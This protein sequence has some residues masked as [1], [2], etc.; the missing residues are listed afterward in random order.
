MG[1]NKLL[2]PLGRSTVIG[3]LLATLTG[4]FAECVLVTDHPDAYRE[5][6]VSLTADFITGPQKNSLTGIHAGLTVSSTPYNFVVAGDMPFVAPGLVRCLAE[7]CAGYDVTIPLQDGH[8]QPLCAVYHKNCLPHIAALL[9]GE[10]Y[11]IIDF[12]PAVRVCRVAA[13][14]LAPYDR[15]LL[16]FFNINTPEDYRLAQELA[17]Q[18]AA[19]KKI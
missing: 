3:T 15:R 5:W 16:S 18:L 19:G 12:F 2:L 10:R 11:K 1:E 9:A 7:R 6:P 4:L 17:S 8:L 13:A 14:D